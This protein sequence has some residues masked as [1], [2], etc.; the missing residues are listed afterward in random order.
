VSGLSRERDTSG[1][2]V[3]SGGSGF[4][5]MAI[6]TG[7]ERG[8]IS[9]TEGIE[10]L[11]TMINFLMQSDRFHG[12]WSHWINGTT[13]E[14]VPF[15]TEDNGGD[16]VETSYTVMGLL[17]VR[18]YLNASDPAEQAL[19]TKINT[20][21][22]SVEWDWYTRG[23]NSLTWHW[24]PN[25][26]WNLNMKIRG[27]NEALITYVLAASSPTHG[28]S[29]TVY[30]GGWKNSSQYINGNLYFGITL[31]LGPDYGGPLFFEQYTFLGLDPRNLNDGTVNYWE[32]AKNH[33]LINRAY[34]E[35]NPKVFAGYSNTCWGLTA[36]DGNNGYSA[37]SP[38]N[39]L[40]VIAPTAALSSFPFT[41]VESMDAM[42]HLYYT[43]G[44]RLW[45]NY[46]F[47]DAF[48]PTENWYATSNIAIDQGPI[49]IM[50]ENH[51][52]GLL[53]DLFMSCPEVQAGLSNLGFNY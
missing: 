46:G 43:L 30:E 14:V 51:R 6:V 37:H 27:W 53:W 7:I 21:W 3:T 32:Q 42:K 18:Q 16:L 48:N 50:I 39:D 13:G 4:G 45:G 12:A 33:T 1:E 8:F 40:G 34:C 38:T 22:E 49:I 23:E 24:S 5:M 10:R 35:A 26:G 41:P 11:T 52:S 2:T 20:L 17:T 36:S 44:D 29:K 47:Y 9:R 25:Y 19:I 31:P 28:I 15:S